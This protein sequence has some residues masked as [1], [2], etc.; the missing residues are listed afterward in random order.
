M[1]RVEQGLGMFH[2]E[3]LGMWRLLGLIFSFEL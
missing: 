3:H 2:V 1:L